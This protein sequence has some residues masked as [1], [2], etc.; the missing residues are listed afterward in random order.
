MLGAELVA[1]G[2][3]L[4]TESSPSGEMACVVGE[5][6]VSV[7]GVASPESPLP[8]QAAAKIARDA[9]ATDSRPRFFAPAIKSGY[10]DWLPD[11]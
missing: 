1:E 3:E 2:W 7:A 6:T 9:K 11:R 10:H 8:P 4:E 5:A